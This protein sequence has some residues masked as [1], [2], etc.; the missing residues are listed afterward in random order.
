M[1]DH[2]NESTDQTD[3]TLIRP[4]DESQEVPGFF[5]NQEYQ[6]GDDTQA[7]EGSD[8]QNDQIPGFVSLDP[9]QE[10]SRNPGDFFD[11]EEFNDGGR[12]EQDE[13]AHYEWAND[14]AAD[15]EDSRDIYSFADSVN[16]R[17][18]AGIS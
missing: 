11:K 4:A 13:K 3:N 14:L 10:E 15:L 2:T 9:L 1:A 7:D 17:F 12:S 16:I 6:E 8:G 18:E 5:D